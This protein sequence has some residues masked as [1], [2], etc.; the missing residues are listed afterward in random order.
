MA[1][2]QNNQIGINLN[3][4][5]GV[6][7]QKDIHYYID[8]LQKGNRYI[9]SETITLIESSNPKKRAIALNIL[10]ALPKPKSQTIRIGIT[11]SPG[12]GKST[13]I[14]SFGIYVLSQG[15]KIAV[16]AIDPSSQINNGSIL[17]DK[18]RMQ[19]LASHPLAY[20]RP[21]ASGSMLGGIAAATKDV[22]QLCE[23]AGYNFI[24]IETVGVGQSEIEVDFITDINLLLLQP[25]A[26]DDMQGI[27]RGVVE[28]ADIFVINKADGPQLEL[29]KQTKTSYTNAIQLF[30]HEITEWTCPVLLISALNKIGLDTVYQ[31]ILTYKNLLIELNLFE[32]KRRFQELRW[33]KNQTTLIV[34]KIIFENYEVQQIFEK[35]SKK[36]ENEDITTSQALNEIEDLIRSTIKAK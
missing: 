5:A 3:F 20:I 30:H 36:I 32:P 31:S 12:V 2:H 17:G 27:K 13:F 11:G 15:H 25:G 19:D 4:T 34:Q 28:N 14:E 21:T 35:L 10:E 29:A 8:G 33:F 7:A 23:A 24:I 18:T 1:K 22:I 16:L 6:K 9:L 26:G